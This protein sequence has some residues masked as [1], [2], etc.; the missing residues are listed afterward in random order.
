MTLAEALD[1]AVRV[2]CTIVRVVIGNAEDRSTW[3]A[4]FSSEAT[5]AQKKEA[6]K[7]IAG[8]AMPEPSEEPDEPSDQQIR[9]QLTAMGLSAP[10]IDAF[11]TAAS[12]L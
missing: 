2:V 12:K 7:V 5:A 9:L 8:F 6:A 4:S 10:Q 3:E 1:A 11:F